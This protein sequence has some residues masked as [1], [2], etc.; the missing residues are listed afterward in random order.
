[1]FFLT[2]NFG[3][4][5]WSSVRLSRTTPTLPGKVQAL[6][7]QNVLLEMPAGSYWLSMARHVWLSN[8]SKSAEEC[9]NSLGT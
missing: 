7:Y 1:M 5:L 8:G 2:G 3:I 9:D 4:C 6:V